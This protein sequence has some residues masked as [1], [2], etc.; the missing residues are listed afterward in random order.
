MQILRILAG[1]T[2]AVLFSLG[3]LTLLYWEWLPELLS[4]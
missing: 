4:F 2:L 1:T 3:F